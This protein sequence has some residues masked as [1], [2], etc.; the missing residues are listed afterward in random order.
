MVS[1]SVNGS[2][3]LSWVA[4]SENVDGSPL[5]DLAGYR[6]YYGDSSRDYTDMTDVNSPTSTATAIVLP[7]GDYYVAMT[8]LDQQGNESTYSNEVMK[9]VQ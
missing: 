5:T 8:A 9:T 2:M 4:P 6:V 1:I 3:S 7:S